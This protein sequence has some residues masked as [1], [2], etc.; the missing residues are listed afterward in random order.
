[1]ITIKEASTKR[2]LKKFADFP[3]RLYR[4]CPYYVP[5]IRINELK[6]ANPKK[7]PS[8]K[9]CRAKYWLAYKGGKLAGRV[10]AIINGL[11]DRKTGLRRVR[12]CRIDFIDD[13]EVSRT[14]MNAVE[15]FAKK[16]GRRDI[17]GPLGFN[18][19]DREGLL[20]EGFDRMSTFETQYNYP[21]YK[22]HLE[23]LG[24]VKEI[25]SEEILYTVPKVHDERISR[26]AQKALEKYDFRILEGMSKRRLIKLYGEKAFRMLDECYSAL[27]CTVPLTGE[28]IKSTLG[29]F[30]LI[31]RLEMMCFVADKDGNVVAG[32]IALPS[33]ADAVRKS[34]GRLTPFS[35]L[36]IIRAVRRP[37]T[38]DLV[39]IGVLPAYRNYGLSAVIIDRVLRGIVASGATLAE[40]NPLLET[41][42]KIHAQF[43]FTDGEVVRRRRFYKKCL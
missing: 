39:L 3:T 37:K 7:N 22:T 42:D 5:P 29:S 11:D 21:Y 19:L 1:M 34:R 36:R 2:D 27:F 38:V 30:G 35:I 18:D 28:A 32:A 20:I 12:F 9:N 41:N 31:A 16:E 6:L 10:S 26:I 14:L 23:D 4:D 43:T 17:I 33:I 15:D 13:R 24:Y 40:S 25:D 8:G